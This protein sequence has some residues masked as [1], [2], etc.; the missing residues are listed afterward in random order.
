M[1]QIL[2]ISGKGGTGKT[3]VAA[4]FASLAE[5]AAI[6]DC[7]VDAPDLHIIL[8]P[9]MISEIPFHALRVA[10]LDESL[11]I[12]CGRCV[13]ACRFK[14]IDECGINPMKCEGCAACAYVCPVKAITMQ[15][16]EAGKIISSE[17]RFGPFVYGVLN[18][19]EEASGKL[20]VGVKNEAVVAAEKA[21]K[22]YLVVDGSPGIGCPVIASLSGVDYAVIVSEPSVSGLHDL[23]RVLGVAAHFGIK[24]G[25]CINKYDL[26][27]K[28]TDEIESYCKKNNVP[29]LGRIRYDPCVYSAMK[30]LKT[31]I[32]RNCPCGRDI[33]D[34]WDKVV[35]CV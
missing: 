8:Q 9:R 22:K 12:S 16:K 18:A 11:C 24:V 32:E 17:T 21:G 5:D 1:K 2:V 6:A 10:T 28:K 4:A 3:T 23:V 34:V 13:R 35:S 30:E 31:V 29:V 15:E 19:G 25:V 7:D 26:N 27:I 33:K 14:A 20:V